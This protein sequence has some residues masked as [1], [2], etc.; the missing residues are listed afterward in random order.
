MSRQTPEE[1][2]DLSSPSKEKRCCSR[3]DRPALPTSQ[4]I[5]FFENRAINFMDED[6]ELRPSRIKYWSEID[7]DEKIRRIR[8]QITQN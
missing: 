6:K 2:A 1:Q 3:P 4:G 8:E 5:Q 7:S